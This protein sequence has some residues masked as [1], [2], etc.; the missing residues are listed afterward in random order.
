[1]P[2]DDITESYL[3]FVP[4]E[5][6]SLRTRL[7]CPTSSDYFFENEEDENKEG[8]EDEGKHKIFHCLGVAHDDIPRFPDMPYIFADKIKILYDYPLENS[9][10]FKHKAT[11]SMNG[12]QYVSVGDFVNF[13]RNDYKRIYDEEEKDLEHKGSDVPR[14]SEHFMN[15][16]ATHGKYGISMHDIDDLVIEGVEYNKKNKVFEMYIGS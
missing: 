3:G 12:K 16:G 5:T 1:M 13:V 8:I 10:I 11:K 6:V 9:V 7:P 4:E 15:R 2:S 14:I